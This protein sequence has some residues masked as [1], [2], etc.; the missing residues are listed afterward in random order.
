MPEGTHPSRDVASRDAPGDASGSLVAFPGV[1]RTPGSLPLELTSFVGREREIAEVKRLSA[2]H[3]CL[4][5]TGPGGCGKSRLALAVAADVR[6]EFEDGAWWVELASLSDPELVPRAVASALKVREQPDQTLTETL[7]DHL[8]PK[9]MLL[10]LDNCEHLV[11]ACAALVGALLRACSSLRVLATS[12]EVLNVAGERAW[13]VPSLSLPDPRRSP[14]VEEL[15]RYEATHLF[16]QRAAD[17]LPGFAP[18][19]GDAEAVAR[20]CHRLDGI[21][22]AVELAAARAKV[23]SVGQISA[24]LDDSIGLLKGSSRSALPRHRTLRATM[25]WSHGL[26]SQDERVLFRRLSVFAGGWT[27]EAAEAV[28]AGEDL[29]RYDVLDLLSSLVDKSLVSVAQVGGGEE[30]RYRILETV[31]QYGREKLEESGEQA[32]VRRLHAGFLLRLAEIAE[33][34]LVGPEQGEWLKRLETEHDNLRAALAWLREEG[35]VEQGLRL[36]GAL[37]RFWWLQD[38]LTE[39]RAQLEALLALPGAEAQTAERAKALYVLGV[40]ASRRQAAGDEAEAR[41]YQRESLSIYRELGD[42]PRT[43]AVLRELGRI[44]IELGDWAT[45]RPFLDESLKL[46]RE[47]GNEHG[48]ALTLYS[49][50][51]LEHFRGENAAARPFLD[52]ALAL[53]RKLGDELY[54]AICWFFLGRIATDEGDYAEA[55]ALLEEIVDERLPQYPWTVPPL[56]E[57][58][59]GLAVAQGEAARALKLAAAAEALRE[60]AGV[61][62]APAWRADLKRRLEPAWRTLGE[63]EGAAAWAQGRAL[64]LEEAVGEAMQEP[65]EW[66]G[67]PPREARPS[68]R[69]FAL[70]PARVEREGRTLTSSDWTYAKSRELLFYLLSHPPRTRAQIG[71][72]LWPDASPDRLRRSFHDT[73][74]HLRRALG[75][76]EWIVFEK[77]R[78]SFNRSLNYFFDAEAFETELAEV[79]RHAA[80]APAGAIVHL[81]RAIELYGGDFL[82][83]LAVEG[84]W[85]LIRREEL[86]RAYQEAL[87]TLGQLH[88]A[89]GRYVQAADVYRKLIGHD[90]LLEAAHRGLMRCL[91]RLGERG[92]AI[93]H[94]RDL[95]DLLRE[96]L[97]SIPAA[98]TAALHERL[99]RGE[100]A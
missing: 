97:G 76:P 33:P 44:G 62:R 36:G 68:L 30:A 56:L 77:G 41:R 55:R 92:R 98:E 96:D 78:Y 81:E 45:A 94:Y 2:S 84:E 71:L 40:L 69:I 39:G 13:L 27:L 99:R 82:D 9:R 88:F 29:E 35:E 60:G 54:I 90:E 18:T 66:L 51:W 23:L 59:A 1:R 70:G 17:A 12:R 89:E 38:H 50:G 24:R 22:L 91:A 47:L 64:T 11:D 7:L 21:P 31:R 74:Y 15:A 61:S 43:A 85:A 95:A 20:A 72:E 10:V 34:A 46:E 52:E 19:E 48:L 58:F 75:R 93:R 5:L 37:W 6:G 100:D 87:L 26:L 65:P 83:D 53:F 57:A 73:L 67:L 16:V 63:R 79:R 8:A 25:D 3:R 42:E 4:T 32:A 80:E 14:S 49:L 28:C 86:R